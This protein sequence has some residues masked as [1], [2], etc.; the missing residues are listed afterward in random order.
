MKKCLMAILKRH[1]QGHVWRQFEEEC[2]VAHRVKSQK[3]NIIIL[4]LHL[5]KFRQEGL[6]TVGE[7]EAIRCAMR[8]KILKY[9]SNSRGKMEGEA[10]RR[11]FHLSN[12]L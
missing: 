1:L 9:I 11:D 5:Q 2:I 10:G 3:E 6:V 12:I 7:I 8:R 4:Y